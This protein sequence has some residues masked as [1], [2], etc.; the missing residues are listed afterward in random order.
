LG[1][2]LNV[3]INLQSLK[4]DTDEAKAERARMLQEGEECQAKTIRF[5]TE[6]LEI[7]NSKIKL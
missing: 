2:Y 7:V 1:A 3:K 4:A 6:I 5:E